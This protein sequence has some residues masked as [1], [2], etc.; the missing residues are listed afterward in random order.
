MPQAQVT[1]TPS[2]M[3]P[4]S[5][6]VRQR[7]STYPPAVWGIH[8][9]GSNLASQCRLTKTEDACPVVSSAEIALDMPEGTLAVPHRHSTSQRTASVIRL[10]SCSASSI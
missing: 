4:H 8:F 9:Q 3:A 10:A 1:A 7:V 6:P 2:R 5:T